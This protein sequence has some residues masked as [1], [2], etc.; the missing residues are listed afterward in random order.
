M[1]WGLNRVFGLVIF[2]LTA[3]SLNARDY[4]IQ[5]RRTDSVPVREQVGVAALPAEIA[6][7][8]APFK[9]PQLKRPVFPA[10]TITITENGAKEGSKVTDIIQQTIEQLS[11]LGGGKV[12]IPKGKWHTGRI[13]LLSNINLEISEGA[14]LYFSGEVEDYRPAV[15]TRNE[16][17]EVM[18]L[19]A[20]IYANGQ[21][22]IAVTGKGKLIGPAKG[23]SVRKQIMTR[24]VIE[25]VVAHTTPVVQRIYEGR[26][27]A[28]IFPPM[29]IS[30][31]NCNNV[32]IEGI[33][34]ENTAFW[35][36]V[37]VYC[38]SVIIRG[39]SVHSIGIPRGDGIDIESSRN[40]LIEYC[41]LSTGD[42]AFTIKAGRGYDGLRVNRPTENV[43]VRNGLVLE[44]HGGITCG[45]ETASMIR[46]LYVHD[47]VFENARSAIRFKTR[48][49]RGGG[50]ENLFYERIRISGSRYAFE[51]DMLGSA[52]HV[53]A[54]ASRYPPRAKDALTPVFRNIKA[55]NIL[56]ENTT[57]FIK[58]IAIP[59][60]P[61]A[62]V[63]I[64]K[65]RSTTDNLI[66]AAD[67]QGLTI[68][69][70]LLSVQNPVVDLLDARNILFNKVTI[71]SPSNKL[72]LKVEG[73]L[74]RQIRFRNSAP[75]KPTGWDKNTWQKSDAHSSSK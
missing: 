57:Q 42:D 15:F 20:C 11:N 33:S 47:C 28:F 2:I 75:S 19:G 44:G 4:R 45:S 74:S 30:P 36:I 55:E 5:D 3:A 38:D 58:A 35:N 16:G 31:I 48:R 1:F 73:P 50:G 22:N 69:N 66:A 32:L 13:T 7:I 60:S 18:S 63:L 52:T 9:M 34:L 61:L 71:I 68:S 10:R 59:E 64:N 24:D 56:I 51:W 23:G 53:G 43:V 37:P 67:V 21:R 17:I 40:V 72:Q 8:N 46:N 6:P 39:I 14:E 29:F 12:M 26:N 70:A 65:I 25:N 27:G 54:A 41:T 62:N 49:P